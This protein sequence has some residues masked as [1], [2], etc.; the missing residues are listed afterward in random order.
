MAFC[1]GSYGPAELNAAKKGTSRTVG[2][3]WQAQTANDTCSLLCMLR[4]FKTCYAPLLWATEHV[5][6]SHVGKLDRCKL[7]HEPNVCRLQMDMTAGPLF[8]AAMGQLGWSWQD[9]QHS[10][11]SCWAV[12]QAQI[13]LVDWPASNTAV[14]NLILVNSQ[15]QLIHV[16]L[17]VS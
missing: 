16:H 9:R 17:A 7:R 11:L 4:T 14:C 15:K 2:V 10:W 13:S 12:W 3:L 8:M 1:S 5:M 6:I